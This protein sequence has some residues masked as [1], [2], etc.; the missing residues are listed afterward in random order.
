MPRKKDCP[1]SNVTITFS[2]DL[3]GY[4]D[5]A[6]FYF[7][8]LPCTD[9]LNFSPKMSVPIVVNGSNNQPVGKISQRLKGCQSPGMKIFAAPETETFSSLDNGV[10]L[11][12]N[13]S[14]N[15]T[16][17]LVPDP[18][19]L[20]ARIP[21]VVREGAS[22]PASRSCRPRPGRAKRAQGC[23]RGARRSPWPRN[24]RPCRKSVANP[25]R[26]KRI[27]QKLRGGPVTGDVATNKCGVAGAP[28]K[29]GKR[30]VRAPWFVVLHTATGTRGTGL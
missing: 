27:R 4:P 7:Q 1:R 20:P 12:Y 26:P 6:E 24:K 10:P 16:I 23:S 9:L 28:W 8:F 22:G 2:T 17:P 18:K 13:S 29:F 25:C 19:H 11:I 30:L 15:R 3:E 21:S 5:F 14:I